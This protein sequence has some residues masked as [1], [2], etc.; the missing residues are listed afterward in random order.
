[1]AYIV[2]AC[3]VVTSVVVARILTAYI[4]V[5]C[6]VYGLYAADKLVSNGV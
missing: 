5:A 6:I 4:S 3:F 1:M 2:V